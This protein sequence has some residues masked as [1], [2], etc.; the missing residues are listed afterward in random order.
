MSNSPDFSWASYLGVARTLSEWPDADEA[1]LRSVISR[2]YYAAFH[3][4][5]DLLLARGD[6]LSRRD[7]HSA[8]WTRCKFHGGRELKPIGA[9][10]LRLR[11]YRVKADYDNPFPEQLQPKVQYALEAAE[12]ILTEVARIRVAINRGDP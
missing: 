5:K 6:S 2:A 11:D 7:V 4:A 10:G 9:R 8:V 3:A 12:F 1:A